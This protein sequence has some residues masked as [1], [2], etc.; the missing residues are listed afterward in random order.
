MFID[1]FFRRLALSICMLFAVYLIRS[2]VK[3]LYQWKWPDAPEPMDMTFPS[4]EGPVFVVQ[5]LGS[6]NTLPDTTLACLPL[7]SSLASA[8]PLCTR[9]ARQ[10]RFRS[11]TVCTPPAGSQHSTLQ[12]KPLS[13]GA[14]NPEPSTETRFSEIFGGM[15]LSGCWAWMVTGFV[16]ALT[17]TPGW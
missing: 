8:T 3:A 9:G 17:P 5:L 1:K 14:E 6:R 10:L 11:R 12:L 2:L 4:W 13:G 16:P 15:I 7:I